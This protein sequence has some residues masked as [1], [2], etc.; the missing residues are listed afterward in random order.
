M[1]LHCPAGSAGLAAT[2]ASLL[3]AGSH[4]TWEL[5]AISEQHEPLLEAFAAQRP[6]GQVQLIS[7]PPATSRSGDQGRRAATI[8]AC[9]NQG[10]ALA[11][12][13]LV[14]CLQTDQRCHEGRL[15][16]PA[17]VLQQHPELDLVWGGW[18][19]GPEQHQ[20]WLRPLTFS[21]A[22]RLSDPCLSAGALTV[23]REA[24]EH[25]QGFDGSLPAWSGV[26]LALRVVAAG[27]Q[28]AW[29]A[30]PLVQSRPAV[31]ASPWSVAMLQQGLK[32]LQRLHSEGLRPE[33]L[34]ELRFAALAWCAGLAWEQGQ[35]ELTRELLLQAALSA[36]LPAPRARVQLLEQFC[37]SQRWCGG[38]GNPQGMLHSSLWVEACHLW[39]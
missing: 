5:V 9:R 32:Q 34:V 21:A 38:S 6:D 30:E 23:R 39:P 24:L 7:A 4:L 17:K 14:A 19:V 25:L 1:L 36:A 26:D 10:L 37:R 22:E 13:P 29:L 31:Q 28:A 18:Q 27:G 15:S 11:R 3:R 8:A 16:L 33:L 35:P 20:P 12:A 2:L